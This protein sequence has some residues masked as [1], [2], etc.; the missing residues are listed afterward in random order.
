MDPNLEHPRR[1]RLLR[2]LAGA[3][4]ALV[5]Y[6]LGGFLLVPPLAR[7]AIEKKGRAALHREVTLREVRFNPFTLDLNLAGL[8]IRDR[9]R[10]PLFDLDRL[11]LQLAPS[12]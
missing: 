4:I 3:G 6:G 7:W 5:V 2:L 10:R 11:H 1:R 12:G 9:D 8:R